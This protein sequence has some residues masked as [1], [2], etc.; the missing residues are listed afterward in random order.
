MIVSWLSFAVALPSGYRTT[1]AAV[2]HA[3][4]DRTQCGRIGCRR[5]RIVIAQGAHCAL[6]SSFP[7]VLAEGRAAQ[8]SCSGATNILCGRDEIVLIEA[9]EQLRKAYEIRDDTAIE[10]HESVVAYMLFVQPGVGHIRVERDFAHQGQASRAPI[11]YEPF[12]VL[13]NRRLVDI[14]QDEREKK[15][16]S[17]CLL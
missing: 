14:C 17:C 4:G 6:Q 12:S 1:C 9:P 5:R 2:A 10:S 13:W 15:S 7:A 16:A 3:A 8:P 11:E